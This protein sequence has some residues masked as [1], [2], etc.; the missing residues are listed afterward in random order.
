[1][2]LQREAHLFSSAH[3]RMALTPQQK[4][5]RRAAASQQQR[6]DEATRKREYRQEHSQHEQETRK[7]R[8]EAIRA[9]A[10]AG[11]EHANAM[12]DA[13]AQ[14]ARVRRQRDKDAADA[15]YFA[16]PAHG[17]APWDHPAYV[18]WKQRADRKRAIRLPGVQARKAEREAERSRAHEQRNAA[19]AA[20][21]QH[22]DRCREAKSRI[23][24]EWY[25]SRTVVCTDTACTH[26]TCFNA[27]RA[28]AVAA[29]RLH[30][31]REQEA[32][33]HSKDALEALRAARRQPLRP[34][35][36]EVDEAESEGWCCDVEAEGCIKPSVSA[37]EP[38]PP[39]GVWFCNARRPCNWCVCSVCHDAQ[40]CHPHVLVYEVTE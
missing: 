32:V 5:D 24:K 12:L 19:V 34:V 23:H 30:L 4:R 11:E 27:G 38:E 40:H 15:A 20:A 39:Y 17:I 18:N 13:M 31:Q 1:M 14:R 7:R 2:E 9:A 26:E 16:G 29:E 21:K 35:R 36:T 3:L 25:V 28:E 8:R 22:Y 37:P 10:D 33:Q 6:D